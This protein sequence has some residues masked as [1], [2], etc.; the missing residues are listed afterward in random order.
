VRALGGE[1]PADGGT[2]TIRAARDEGDF[3]GKPTRSCG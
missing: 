2:D 1:T 3:A